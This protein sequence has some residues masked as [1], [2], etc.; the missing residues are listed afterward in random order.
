MYNIRYPN[1][2]ESQW[3]NDRA[4]SPGHPS[5]KYEFVSWDDDSNP[6]YGKIKFM[7]TKPPTRYGGI[8]KMGL[9]MATPIQAIQVLNASPILPIIG[10]TTDTTPRP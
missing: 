3:R 10:D 9:P 4:L 7:A 1:H 6:I 5:E 2:R 8:P